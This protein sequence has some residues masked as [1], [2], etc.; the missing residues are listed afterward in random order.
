MYIWMNDACEFFKIFFVSHFKFF[1]WKKYIEFI[2]YQSH[3]TYT[4]SVCVCVWL[5]CSNTAWTGCVLFMSISL[6]CVFVCVC[7]CNIVEGCY[8]HWICQWVFEKLKIFSTK[9]KF[10]DKNRCGPI[11]VNYSWWKNKVE[12]LTSLWRQRLTIF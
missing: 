10:T 8:P 11:I 3:L 6:C 4:L 5:M 1:N 2:F 9:K 7:V 12:T